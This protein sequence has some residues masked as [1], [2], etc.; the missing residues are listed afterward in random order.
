M[1]SISP[2]EIVCLAKSERRAHDPKI[3]LSIPASATDAAAV[4]PN[5]IK[6]LLANGLIHFSLKAS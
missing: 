6:T 4:N 3:S 1:S 5:I 2:L